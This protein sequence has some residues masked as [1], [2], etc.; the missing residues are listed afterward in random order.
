MAKARSLHGNADFDD[1]MRRLVRVP[2]AELAKEE[3]K[4]K[5]MRKR[6]RA[7]KAKHKPAR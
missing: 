7:K 6:P 5:A 2:P 1:A 3:A 4:Y